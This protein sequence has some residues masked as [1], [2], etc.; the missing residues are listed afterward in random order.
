MNVPETVASVTKSSPVPSLELRGVSKSFGDLEVLREVS[1]TVAPGAFVSLVGP[2]GCGKSTLLEIVAGLIPPSRGRVLLAG[3]PLS[4]AG[5]AGY[6]PQGDHLLPWR[7]LLHNVLLGPELRGAPPKEA[8]REASALL[9]RFGLGGFEGSYPRELSGGMRQ[10]AALLRAVM[11]E[12]CLLILDETL[13][14]LDALTR[15][16]MQAWLAGLVADLE[17]TALLVT[18]DVR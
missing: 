3:E 9:F 14:A 10:R 12:R 15:L 18:H 16:Q 5:V 6:M 11:Y 8:E 2:S 13:G 4:G 7:T 17:A 1:S